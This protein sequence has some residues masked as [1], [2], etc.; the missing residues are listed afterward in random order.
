M[1]CHV[2][3]GTVC[4]PFCSSPSW[5]EHGH[6]AGSSA[7]GLWARTSPSGATGQEDDRGDLD[8]GVSSWHA[9]RLPVAKGETGL[10]WREPLS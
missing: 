5:L 9:A 2:S 6:G 10:R 8:V 3:G 7:S 4:P 1:P